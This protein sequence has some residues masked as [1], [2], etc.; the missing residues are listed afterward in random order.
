MTTEVRFF[1]C[2][3]SVEYQRALEI[4]AEDGKVRFEGDCKVKYLGPDVGPYIIPY[5]HG[6]EPFVIFEA[7]EFV[8]WG[9]EAK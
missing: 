2:R 3:Y 1:G 8:S 4:C 9:K 7:S 6:M 5:W